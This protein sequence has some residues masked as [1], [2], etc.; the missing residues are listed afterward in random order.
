MKHQE[1]TNTYQIVVWIRAPLPNQ[2]HRSV[3]TSLPGLIAHEKK[4]KV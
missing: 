4:S 3:Y 1:P 2:D